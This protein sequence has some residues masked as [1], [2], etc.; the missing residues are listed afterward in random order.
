MGGWG[1]AL[2]AIR[3]KCRFGKIAK[4]HGGQARIYPGLG[5]TP[6]EG[7]WAFATIGAGIAI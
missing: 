6:E 5:S 7:H 2:R 4:A 3:E 1:Y